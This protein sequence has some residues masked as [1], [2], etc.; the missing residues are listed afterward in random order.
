VNLDKTYCASDC[1]NFKCRDII[2]YGVCIA[3]ERANK[4][5]SHADLSKDCTD[6]IA[7]KPKKD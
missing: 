1:Q 2:S 6:Y 5:L 3:A 4:S 7:I